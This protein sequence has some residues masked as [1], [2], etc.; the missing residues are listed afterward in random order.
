MTTITEERTL[1]TSARIGGFEEVLELPYDVAVRA[2][3]AMLATMRDDSVTPVLSNA[4]FDG[5]RLLA[6]DRYRCARFDL[7]TTPERKDDRLLLGAAFHIPIGALRW[8]ARVKPDRTKLRMK[9]ATMT[10]GGYSVRFTQAGGMVVV[11]LIDMF[12]K[13]EDSEAFR[14]IVG[15]FPRLMNLFT[16]RAESP[17]GAE[18]AFDPKLLT[19]ITTWAAKHGGDTP[20]LLQLGGHPGDQTRPGCAR[21]TCGSATFLVMPNRLT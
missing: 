14:E 18:H 6:T 2:S 17:A 13:L 16:R 12:G 3:A 20:F 21:I 10:S 4:H 7:P 9:L 5:H 8:V 15:N 19:P 1:E 11:D